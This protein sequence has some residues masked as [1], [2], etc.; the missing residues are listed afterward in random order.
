MPSNHPRQSGQSLAAYV[1]VIAVV[2][3]AVILVLGVLVLAFSG[4][5]LLQ[6]GVVGLVLFWAAI[7]A[8]SQLWPSGRSRIRRPQADKIETTAEEPK[9]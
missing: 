6:Q 9:K 7:W 5:S 1:L 2:S 8:T 4:P 3:L